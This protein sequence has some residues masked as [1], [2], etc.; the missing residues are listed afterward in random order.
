VVPPVPAQARVTGNP[1]MHQQQL[2][3]P[4]LLPEINHTES[5]DNGVE[6]VPSLLLTP[7]IVTQ[8]NAAEVYKDDETLFP[9]TQE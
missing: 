2:I 6:V 3:D 4:E 5:Y 7:L 1:A 8:A 9:L